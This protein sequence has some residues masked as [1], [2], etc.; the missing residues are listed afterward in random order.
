MLRIISAAPAGDYP[1]SV[2]KNKAPQASGALLSDKGRY[3]PG[4]LS[5]FETTPGPSRPK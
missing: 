4:L 2:S 1:S 3:L 5:L